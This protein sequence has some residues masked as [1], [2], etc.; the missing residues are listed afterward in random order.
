MKNK[1]KFC[2]ICLFMVFSAFI[3]SC[4]PQ[5]T[6]LEGPTKEAVL[7]YSEAKTDALLEGFTSGDY[8]TFSQDF[9]ADMRKA[10]GEAQFET[11]K[12]ERD[13][14][15]GGYVSRQV[16]SVIQQGDF[17]AVIYDTKFEKDDDVKMRV[18]FRMKEPHEI[19]G[20]WFNK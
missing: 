2:L 17:Y 5:A 20:L 16:N 6:P 11:L 15:F 18:V 12:K 8:A 3:V 10:I 14:K 19:S 9:D 13:E 7:V 1:D 4:T